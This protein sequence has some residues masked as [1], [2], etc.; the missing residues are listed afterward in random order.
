MKKFFDPIN[1][2]EDFRTHQYMKLIYMK[3]NDTRLCDI[4]YNMRRQIYKKYYVHTLAIAFYGFLF[5]R[6]LYLHDVFLGAAH[7][8]DMLYL[9]TL[10]YRFQDISVSNSS[11]STM[12]DRMTAVW[13]NFARYGYDQLYRRLYEQKFICVSHIFVAVVKISGATKVELK[14]VIL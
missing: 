6:L 7:H 14:T 3:R 1:N 12:V 10:R 2:S 9:M 5:V 11:D 13:Y 8:D 4:N